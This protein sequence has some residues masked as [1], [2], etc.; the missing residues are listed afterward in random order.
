[1]T[2]I[3]RHCSCGICKLFAD[4]VF[5]RNHEEVKVLEKCSIIV[6]ASKHNNFIVSII[7]VF[8]GQTEGAVTCTRLS[9]E[10]H[11]DT[12]PRGTLYKNK[13]NETT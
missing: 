7:A 4:F 11:L 3:G 13:T 10:R 9:R 2:R 6:S 5:E 1:M 8:V 12:C